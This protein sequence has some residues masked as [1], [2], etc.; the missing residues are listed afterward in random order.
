[1]KIRYKILNCSTPT[2]IFGFGFG[3]TRGDRIIRR[4]KA[5]PPPSINS[6]IPSNWECSAL[7][8][9]HLP[10][11]PNRRENLSV[12]AKRVEHLQIEILVGS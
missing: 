10:K 7:N 3:C 8:L 6:Q 1:M 4:G 2:V 5:F 11:T 12:I 9:Q